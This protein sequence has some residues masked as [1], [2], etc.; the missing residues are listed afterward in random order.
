MTLASGQPPR[1][2]RWA[3]LGLLLAWSWF[4]MTVSHELG[5]VAGGWASGAELSVLEIRPWRL[6]YSLFAF[7][8]QP[9]V[10]L[11]AGPILGCAGPLLVALAIRQPAV[12]FVAWF[13]MLANAS[14][15]LLG[16]LSNDPELDSQK[17]IKAGTPLYVILLFAGSILP[18]SY[19][20]F[21]G[22]CVRLLTGDDPPL[23]RRTWRI[24]TVTLLAALILQSIAGTL[25]VAR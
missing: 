17:L 2:T 7:D 19:I 12:R 3:T 24:S 10:T 13:C 21:R 15:L 9:L 25:I 20:A 1:T 14:Y 8:P 16:T 22:R 23:A 11:W 4:V 18:F 5:H 6:P